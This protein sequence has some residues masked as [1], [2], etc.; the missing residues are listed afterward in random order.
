MLLRIFWIIPLFIVYF[1]LGGILFLIPALLFRLV[2]LRKASDAL[3]FG[4]LK[5]MSNLTLWL[6][7]IRVHVSGDIDGILKRSREGEGFCFVSNH[8]SMLD[9]VLMMGRLRVHTG[10]VAKRVLLLIPVLN[11]YIAMTH[12]VFIDRKS[13]KSSVASV[14]KAG[15]NIKK[16]LSMLIYP[17][18]TRS[19]TGQIG[20]FHHGSFRMATENGAEIVPV[21]V[22]GLRDSLEG[23]RH[24]FQR[25]QCYVHIGNP[26]KAP[27]AKDREAVSLLISKVEGEIRETY[28]SLD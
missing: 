5:V 1:G 9:I 7:G 11:L 6:L 10:Y 22:K 23:R 18:G 2:G 12:S 4:S 8:T 28:N 27:S 17:E 20:K 14:R 15:D 19:K 24:F 21:T 25:R 13:L 26:V 16:G 3:V